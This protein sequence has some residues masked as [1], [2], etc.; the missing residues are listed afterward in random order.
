M[1]STDE[2]CKA[3]AQHNDLHPPPHGVPLT[4]LHFLGH[5]C[6]PRLNTRLQQGDMPHLQGCG[7]VTARQVLVQHSRGGV[8]TWQKAR[9]AV[10]GRGMLAGYSRPPLFNNQTLA[11]ALQNLQ[12]AS[13][14]R[15]SVCAGQG[16]QGHRWL[17][18]DGFRRGGAGHAVI[19]CCTGQDTLPMAPHALLSCVEPEQDGH[20]LQYARAS[21]WCSY[22][23][24]Q[25]NSH[26]RCCCQHVSSAEDTLCTTGHGTGVKLMQDRS[27]TT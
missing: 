7:W 12:V 2:S 26:A 3:D 10:S 25:V 18:W 11:I 14:H 8:H 5:P 19:R 22:L 24:N 17:D 27:D 13:G 1:S 9:E 23:Q 20:F 16:H 6:I 15:A 4:T 21:S